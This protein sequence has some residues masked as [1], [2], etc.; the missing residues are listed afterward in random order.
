MAKALI[1][2]VDKE[3]SIIHHS[4]FQKLAL[5]LEG[6]ATKNNDEC[7][8]RS[9]DLPITPAPHCQNRCCQNRLTMHATFLLC[10]P[11]VVQPFLTAMTALNTMTSVSNPKGDFCMATL[12]LRNIDDTLK[13]R[14]RMVA[15]ANK[16][17][18]EEEVRQILRQHLLRSQC[19][20]RM[21]T[22]ISRR[23]AE[24]GGVDLPTP[25]RS[26]PRTPAFFDLDAEI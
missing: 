7:G 13:S 10:N 9:D 12:T 15:A 26:L 11:S 8:M 5:T 14:L 6:I 17:S 25:L 22:R 19:S 18:M 23:F 3:G 24:V 20:E 2:S 4:S 21:G 16:R 1:I